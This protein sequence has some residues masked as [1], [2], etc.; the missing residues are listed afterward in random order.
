MTITF[1]AP[2]EQANAVISTNE[3]KDLFF[4]GIPLD[5]ISDKTL[6]FYIDSATREV[7]SYLNI[8]ILPETIVESQDFRLNEF[9]QFGYVHTNYPVR[10]P[11]NLVGKIDNVVYISF[12]STKLLVPKS[13]TSAPYP[14]Q[15]MVTPSLM[16]VSNYSPFWFGV[17]PYRFGDGRFMPNFWEVT[18]DT[19]FLEI[20]VEL[21]NVVGK[22]A[23][24]N[25]FYLLGDLITGTPGLN[26]KTISIDGLSQNFSVGKGGY[27]DRISNYLKELESALPSLRSEY[28]G[29]EFISM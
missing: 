4:A 9:N 15:L 17:F 14:K 8:K 22:L 2:F 24:L 13:S 10:I 21:A 19:G 20:P 3:L 1:S 26:T 6:E 16:S 18:Y 12:D 11:T 7:E 5:K 25:V 29:I 28:T 23:A 27:A